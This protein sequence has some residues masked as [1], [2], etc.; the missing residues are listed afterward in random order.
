MNNLE[1]Y[2]ELIKHKH[3]V[4]GADHYN[5]LGIVRTLGENKIPVEAIILNS[6]CRM[7]SKSKFID[8]VKYVDT[9]E[10]GYQ[11]LLKRYGAEKE[12]TYIYTSDDTITELLNINYSELSNKFFFYN[13][14]AANRVAYYMNKNNILEAAQRAGLNTLPTVLTSKGELDHGIEY[15][16]ITKASDPLEYGWKNDMVICHSQEDLVN[17]YKK[18]KSNNVLIQHYINKKNEY[19]LEGFS[20]NKGTHIFISILSTYNY[21]LKDTYSPLMTVNNFKNDDLYN[22]LTKLFKEIQ[23]EGIF[24]VEFLVDSDNNFYFSEINFRNSTWS[25]AST[26]AGMPLPIFWAESCLGIIRKNYYND[27]KEPFTAVVEFDDFRHR[28]KEK[29][30]SFFRWY[31]DIRSCRCKYYIGRNDPKPFFASLSWRVK[32]ALAKKNE[33]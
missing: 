22:K 16:I 32:K 15:P 25:Y 2:N 10:E 11:Y 17:A 4:F 6:P 29:K 31:M 24:E 14:G 9:P 19:C 18:I 12:K 30:Y 28:V 26:I 27:I 7:I 1:S 8:S 23:F 5:S 13:A 3:V 20:Y 33:T 21:L